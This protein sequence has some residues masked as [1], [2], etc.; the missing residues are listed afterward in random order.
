MFF[1][2]NNLV[3][4]KLAPISNVKVTEIMS[5][6]GVNATGPF[7]KQCKSIRGLALDKSNYNNF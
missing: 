1:D 2:D 5:Y 4:P 6:P 3:N 7:A